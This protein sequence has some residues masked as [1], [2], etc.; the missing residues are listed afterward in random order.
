MDLQNSLQ[1]SVVLINYGEK[2]KEDTVICLHTHMSCRLSFQK[3][4][5][6]NIQFSIL[7]IHRKYNKNC[8]DL[9]EVIHIPKCNQ[10]EL[11]QNLPDMSNKKQHSTSTLF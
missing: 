11:Y 4:D 1:E 6:N 8:V 3:Y 10:M 7:D 5:E 2:S 9:L